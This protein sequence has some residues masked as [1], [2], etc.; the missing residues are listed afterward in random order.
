MKRIF[1]AVAGLLALAS[2]PALASEPPA[3]VPAAV[4]T[5]LAV[6]CTGTVCPVPTVRL[7]DPQPTP[8]VPSAV[9]QALSKLTADTNLYEQTAGSLSAAKIA[10]QA[11]QDNYA[12]LVASASNLQTQVAADQ[13]ALNTEMGILVVNPV[14][15][16]NPPAH[17]VSI[18]EIG[19]SQCGA[20]NALD[21]LLKDI[22]AGG[23]KIPRVNVDAD[24][25]ALATYKPV[26]LPTFL[27][28][29]DGKEVFRYPSTVAD[30]PLKWDK[31]MLLDWYT[32]TQAW[33]KVAYPQ[34]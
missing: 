33:T 22:A 1:A 4:K 11:A 27:M 21:P 31:A 15:P 32:R 17:P 6:T 9:Q 5:S 7:S 19:G 28:Q 23:L 24:P 20:C 3:S 14:N 26:S 12:S 34:P 10:L 16:V 2:L 25:T 18:V 30:K 8:P 13:A 29:V